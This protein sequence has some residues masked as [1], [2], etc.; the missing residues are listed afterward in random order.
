MTQTGHPPRDIR[1][2][3]SLAYRAP[4]Q[5]V[6]AATLRRSVSAERLD[7]GCTNEPY[8]QNS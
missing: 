1:H 5:S 2:Y 3:K 4:T 8:G 7:L 6:M